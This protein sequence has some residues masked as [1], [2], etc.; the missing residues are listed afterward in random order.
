MPD[1]GG[2]QPVAS[3]G[4][5]P[6]GEMLNVSYFGVNET[7]TYNSRLQLTRMTSSIW[8][9]NVMDMQY[10]YSATQRSEEHTSELQS[11]MYLVCRLLL[12]KTNEHPPQIPSSACFRGHLPH[13]G[14]DPT[15]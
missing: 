2:P 12:A 13:G 15:T 3:A 5:G 1:G 9:S 7:R 8:G 6:A 4:Y 11:P 10:N 14:R